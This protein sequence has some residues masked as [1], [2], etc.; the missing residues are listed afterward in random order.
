MNSQLR[1]GS[2]RSLGSASSQLVEPFEGCC[3]IGNDVGIDSAACVMPVDGVVSVAVGMH[4]VPDHS[5]GMTIM[6][7]TRNSAVVLRHARIDAESRGIDQ[8]EC[9]AA[10]QFCELAVQIG[11]PL[12][13]VAVRLDVVILVSQRPCVVLALVSDLKLLHSVPPMPVDW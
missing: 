10:T 9:L 6:K 11:F 2:N 3:P 8:D 1:F 7:G 12:A 13:N 4:A 5:K